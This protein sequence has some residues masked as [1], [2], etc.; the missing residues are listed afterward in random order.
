M[1]IKSLD[2]LGIKPVKRYENPSNGGRKIKSLEELGI[3]PVRRQQDLSGATNNNN[4]RLKSLEELGIQPINRVEHVK[5]EPSRQ[6]EGAPKESKEE[7]SYGDRALQLARGFSNIPAIG[8]DLVNNY[9]AAPILNAAGGAAELASKGAGYVSKGAEDVLRHGAEAAYK[10]RDFYKES[11]LTG[12]VSD[13]FNELAGKDITPKDTTG[14]ILNATGEFAFPFSNVAKGAKGVGQAASAVGKHLGVAAGGGAALEG[15]KDYRITEEGTTGRVVEDFLQTVMGMSLAD[16]G[17]SAAKRKIID[18]TEK[19]L[20]KIANNTE[21]KALKLSPSEDIGT[22]RKGLAK[23]LSLGANPN[24]EANAAAAAEGVQLPFEVALNGRAQKFLANTGLKSLFVTKGYN[25]V[26]EHADRD[27]IN[28]VKRKID[29]INPTQ[30]D[31]ELSSTKALEHLKAEDAFIG[32][33][34]N[35]LYERSSSLLK[36]T[37]SVKPEKMYGA[38]NDILSKISTASPSKDMQFVANRISRIGKAW[39]LLPDLSKF[40][41]SPALIGKIKDALLKENKIK[42]IPAKEFELQIKALK[43]DLNYERDIPGIKNLLNGF[44]SSMEKDLGNIANKEYLEARGAANKYF[45]E[46]EVDRIRTNIAQS[47]MKGEVPK[48]AFMYMS[49]AP[50]IRQLKKIMGESEAS[51]EIMTSLKRAKLEDVLVKN[52]LDSSGTLSYANFSNMFNKAPE[53]Q[54]LLKELLGEQYPGM[55]KLAEVS[56]QFVTA[57]KDFGNPSRTTLSAADKKGVIDVIKVLGNTAATVAGSTALH[58]IGFGMAVEPLGILALSRVASDKKIVNTAIKYAEAAK[59]S[60]LKD[61]EILGNRLTRMA[62]NVL[63][64]QWDE[65]KNH[66]QASL[67]LSQKARDGFVEDKRKERQNGKTKPSS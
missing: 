63:K 44:I 42:E 49:S 61:A 27:M 18:N 9:V 31:G 5:Q 10:A 14:K 50:D 43:N 23:A 37:D 40:E 28:A 62:G 16:K 4:R 51:N 57:G 2:E 48:Q 67:V 20:S 36:E 53:K 58:G 65:I 55:K 32:K 26:I 12:N 41:D 47:L 1:A 30:L 59:N 11:N 35:N 54:A 33:E 19:T 45:K 17:L 60:K 46:N 34:V 15:T 22:L 64:S 38:M 3:Q 21:Q 8:A 29:Q 25:N 6:V 56:Q 13:A 39:G 66:P 7:L 24:I 52:I